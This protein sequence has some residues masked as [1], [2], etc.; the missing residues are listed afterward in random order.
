MPRNYV[1]STFK[2]ICLCHAHVTVRTAEHEKKIPC[3]EC[4]RTVKVLMGMGV[5]NYRCFI[6]DKDGKEYKT[7][8]IHV[9]Q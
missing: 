7:T 8:P 1:P 9:N 2:I 5:N 3:W 4:G 6:I